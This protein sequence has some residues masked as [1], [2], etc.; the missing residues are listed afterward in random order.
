MPLHDVILTPDDVVGCYQ[1]L[2]REWMPN[3]TRDEARRLRLPRLFALRLHESLPAGGF[4]ESWDA[5]PPRTVGVWRLTGGTELIV[6]FMEASVRL[7]V[8]RRS[9][10][11][12]FYGLAEEPISDVASEP[13]RHHGTVL[14]SR[15]ACS[16]AAKPLTAQTEHHY[17]KLKLTRPTLLEIDHYRL[18]GMAR[19]GGGLGRARLRSRGVPGSAQR[20]VMDIQKFMAC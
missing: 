19:Q 1:L 12:W 11:R 16:P 6:S 10:D 15:V 5:E 4:V 9:S 14:F 13:K 18:R 20:N 8:R 17:Q 3:L 2:S 7:I